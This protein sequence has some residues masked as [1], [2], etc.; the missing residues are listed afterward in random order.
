[1]DNIILRKAAAADSDFA[2]N[3]RKAALKEYLGFVVYSWR[4]WI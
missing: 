4:G 3:T 2:Y 1:M